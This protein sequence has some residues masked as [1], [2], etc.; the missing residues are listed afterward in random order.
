MSYKVIEVHLDGTEVTLERFGLQSKAEERVREL[1]RQGYIHCHYKYEY[2]PQKYVIKRNYFERPGY[3]RTIE[4]GLFLEEAQAH[5][6]DPETSSRTATSKAARRRTREI[7]E[8]F[9]S[10]T[11]ER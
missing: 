2:D 1:Y 7:G 10:F 6:R 8:W 11:A 3:H 9:D 5:C 4:R